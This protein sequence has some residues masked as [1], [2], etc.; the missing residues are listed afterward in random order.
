MASISS[1]KITHGEQSRARLKSYRIAFSESP[2]NL[3]KSSGPFIATKFNLDSVAIALAIIVLQHPGG[4]NSNTPLLGL[5][6]ILAN[7]S[8]CFRGHSMTFYISFLTSS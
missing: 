4:P 7:A 2:T 3:L 8:G 6:F 1:K 5:M